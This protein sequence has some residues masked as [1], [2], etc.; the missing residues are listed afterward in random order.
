M[1]QD[2]QIAVRISKPLL[3][4]LDDIRRNEKEPPS[5]AEMIRRLIER[6]G[7]AASSSDQPGS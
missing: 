4:M 6:A 3:E 7:K 1:M 2:T 5:R